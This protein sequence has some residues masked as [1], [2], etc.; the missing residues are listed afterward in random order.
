MTVF[1]QPLLV[2]LFVECVSFRVPTLREAGTRNLDSGDTSSMLKRAV[3]DAVRLVI[4]A[5]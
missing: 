1:F 2:L 5:E 4:I 3:A